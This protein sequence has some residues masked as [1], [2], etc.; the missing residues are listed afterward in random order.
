MLQ[1]GV[2]A[3]PRLLIGCLPEGYHIWL[4][5]HDQ[6]CDPRQSA[7]G[8]YLVYNPLYEIV[9]RDINQLVCDVSHLI[10]YITYIYMSLHYFTCITLFSI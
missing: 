3:E 9:H 4:G 2:F 10:I 6:H 8:V 1:G 7:G 5:T